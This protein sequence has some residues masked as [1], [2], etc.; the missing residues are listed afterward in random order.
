[1]LAG[2][3]VG[4]AFQAKMIEAWMVLPAFALVYLLEAPGRL[5]QRVRRLVVAGAVAAVVSLAWMSVVALVPGSDRPY[6]DGSHHDSPYE[7]VFVYNGFGRFGQQT[8]LQI[9]AGQSLG[10]GQVV[11]SPPVGPAR[12]LSGDLGRDTGW[13]LPAA[14]VGAVWGGLARRRRPRGDPLRAGFLL[15]GTWLIVLAVVFSIT[16]TINAYYTA[17]LTPAVAGLAGTGAVALWTSARSSRLGR[18]GVAVVAAGGAGY[19]AWLVRS[20]G[21]DAPGWVFPVVVAVGALGVVAAIG[22]VVGGGRRALAA[23]V[24]GMLVAGCVGPAAASADGVHRQEGAFDTPFEPARQRA[25]ITQLFV[26][27]PADVARLIPALERV[28]RGA[29]WLLATQT[30]AVASVF[31]AAS[32]KE[33]LPLGGFT[34]TIPTPTIA[35]LARWVREGRFHLTLVASTSDPRTRW[36]AAHCLDVGAA[37]NNLHNYFC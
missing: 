31:I 16:T 18:T 33:A 28:Q 7:Q 13:L 9:L 20:P 36:I 14:V 21:A 19:A 6:V 23:G 15:W 10:I 3:G 37:A 26:T 1:M 5:G 34:G 32:G 22:A 12:L 27:T 29:P 30:A 35:Q 8:P 25:A 2:V 24:T 4:L 11:T 17:A